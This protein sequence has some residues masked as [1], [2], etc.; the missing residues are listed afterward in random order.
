MDNQNL[1]NIVN[2]ENTKLWNRFNDNS[3]AERNRQ[4]F[5]EEHG[6]A[7][8]EKN[9]KFYWFPNTPKNIEKAISKVKR[10]KLKSE[11][12]K[13]R[14]LAVKVLENVMTGQLIYI[15]NINKF[16]KEEGIDK[17]N[18]NK[19][20]AGK[21]YNAIGIYR[22][23]GTDEVSKHIY[24]SKSYLKW[25]QEHPEDANRD[26]KAEVEAKKARKSQENL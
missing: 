5:V 24:R 3:K 13:A 14:K 17:D 21:L 26:I 18:F 8:T 7:F 22:I 16:C 12:P 20:F 11:N 4:K 23:P 1:I 25:I 9:G 19:M 6:G 10:P 2:T 15:S